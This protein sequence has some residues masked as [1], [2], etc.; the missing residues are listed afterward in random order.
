[1]RR[2]RQKLFRRIVDLSTH[3][4]V[5]LAPEQL[6]E[7]WNVEVQT[8]RK[9]VRENALEGFRVGRALRIRREVALAFEEA[10]QLRKAG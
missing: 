6:A 1:M 10:G 4:E 8:I 2:T 3:D 7:L 5:N 9:W